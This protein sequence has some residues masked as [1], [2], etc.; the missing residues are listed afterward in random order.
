MSTFGELL[1]AMPLPGERDSYD[2]REVRASTRVEAKSEERAWWALSLRDE[3]I[4]ALVQQ[5][6]LQREGRQV[7]NAAFAPVEASTQTAPMCLDIAKALACGGKYDVGLIDAGCES[8]ALTQ[9]LRIETPVYAQPIW[10]VSSRLWLVPRQSWRSETESQLVTD[11]DLERLHDFMGEF[12]F[13]IVYCAPVS[14]PT[15]R[16]ARGCDGLVL[17]LTANKTRRLVA[18]RIKD[19]LAKAQVPLLGTVLAERRL[20]VPQGLYRKL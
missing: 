9:Q 11:H 15:A 2:F 8:A 6:F 14:W 12:D 3:Q 10:P 16:I 20:P 13:S 18:A 19:Q 1:R 4:Q 17:I 5:L 7:R